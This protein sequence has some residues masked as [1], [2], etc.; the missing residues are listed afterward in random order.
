LNARLIPTL[1]PRASGKTRRSCIKHAD[2][3]SEKTLYEKAKFARKA[4]SSALF[5]VKSIQSKE[6]KSHAA[7]W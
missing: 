4:L 3:S 5:C 7:R 2:Y 1:I 6:G